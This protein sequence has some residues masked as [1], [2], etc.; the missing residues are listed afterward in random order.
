[1]G[2]DRELD[3]EKVSQKRPNLPKTTTENVFDEYLQTTKDFY[4]KFTEYRK[5]QH[6]IYR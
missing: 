3:S 5:L 6:D 2:I 1:M 4:M